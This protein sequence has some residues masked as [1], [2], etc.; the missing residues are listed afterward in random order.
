MTWRTWTRQGQMGAMDNSEPHNHDRAGLGNGLFRGAASGAMA[1]KKPIA[2]ILG[3]LFLAHV[4]I[5]VGNSAGDELYLDHEITIKAVDRPFMDVIKDIE[6]Q[7]GVKIVVKKD[8]DKKV[9]LNLQHCRLE[10]GLN[11][12]LA[13]TD[14]SIIFDESASQVTILVLNKGAGAKPDSRTG[15]GGQAGNKGQRPEH[16][17]MEASSAA[18]KD[19]KLYQQKGKPGVS[20]T[21]K[22]ASPMDA[23]SAALENYKE[24]KNKK[25]NNK[26]HITG[27]ANSSPMEASASALEQF[28]KYQSQHSVQKDTKVSKSPMEQSW[29]ALKQYEEYKLHKKSDQNQNR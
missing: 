24:Y 21:K 23:S 3:L 13:G 9:T 27:S 14:H 18:L 28:K 12:L 2:L 7:T 22:Q 8:V 15:A 29:Q 11:R 17:P 26:T 5:L 20:A 1:L 4:S 10:E 6:R 25:G 19:Y 16:S